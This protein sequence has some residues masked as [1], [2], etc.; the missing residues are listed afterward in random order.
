MLS[1]TILAPPHHRE[2]VNAGR[3]EVPQTYTVRSWTANEKPGI[4]IQAVPVFPC[5]RFGFHGFGE[6][7]TLKAEKVMRGLNREVCLIMRWL[8]VALKEADARRRG[9]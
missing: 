1:V 2:E 6:K 7:I 4:V 8:E 3:Q 5:N 9:E